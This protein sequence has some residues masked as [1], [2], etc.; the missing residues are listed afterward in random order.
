[1]SDP[2]YLRECMQWRVYFD[3]LCAM[4]IDVLWVSEAGER[5]GQ[6]SVELPVV[7]VGSWD[8]PEWLAYT[9]EAALKKLLRLRPPGA[10]SEPLPLPAGMR[11]A[12]TVVM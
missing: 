8:D 10:H 7:D 11:H 1:M 4:R 5:L 9:R 6:T 3:D 2:I 12:R